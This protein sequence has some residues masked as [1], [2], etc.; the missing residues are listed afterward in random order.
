MMSATEP[1]HTVNWGQAFAEVVLIVIGVGM[2]LAVDNWADSRQEL[3]EEQQYLV[4]LL[5]DF[6]AT[7]DS[8]GRTL[9]EIRAN[10]D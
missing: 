2:A 9:E 10:R 6:E 5:D 4:R 8:L 1:R 3:D 7:R